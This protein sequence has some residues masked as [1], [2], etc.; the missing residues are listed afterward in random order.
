VAQT[1]QPAY[2]AVD[3]TGTRRIAYEESLTAGSCNVRDERGIDGVERG[4]AQDATVAIQLALLANVPIALWGAP[5]TGKTSFFRSVAEQL[6]WPFHT[7]TAAIHEATDFSGLSFLSGGTLTAHTMRA[8]LEWAVDLARE[9]TKHDGNGLLFFDDLGFAPL[10]VQNALLQ[11]VLER[12]VDQFQLPSG[13]RCTAA[14]EPLTTARGT[15]ALTAP[16]ANRM[17]H[18]DWSPDAEWW[19]EG[20][21]S[22]W[23]FQFQTLPKDWEDHLPSMRNRVAAFIRV[24]PDLLNS[25]PEEDQARAGAWPSGRTWDMLSRLLAACEAGRVNQEVRTL[26]TT[27]AV[28]QAA[29]TDY[30][31]WEQQADVPAG[32]LIDLNGKTRL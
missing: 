3:A 21:L 12:R 29:G 1:A 22:N 25:E 8:P 4:L 14:L 17:V 30:L 20:F 31:T 26:L 7:T 18:I 27:G 23:Q 11:I 32:R 10:G 13:V 9:A 15:S 5:G 28:G 2:P 6:G 19:V 24:R 16:L